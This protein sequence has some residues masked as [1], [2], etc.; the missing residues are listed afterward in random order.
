MPVTATVVYNG[1]KFCMAAVQLGDH[2]EAGSVKYALE[3]KQ[4]AERRVRPEVLACQ[5]VSDSMSLA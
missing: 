2:L 4:R 5:C 3:E 1:N